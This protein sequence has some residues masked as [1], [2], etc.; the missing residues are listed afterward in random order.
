MEQVKALEKTANRLYRQ[1]CQEAEIA[2][3]MSDAAALIVLRKAEEIVKRQGDP[4]KK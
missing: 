3:P 2:K 1:A 4:K